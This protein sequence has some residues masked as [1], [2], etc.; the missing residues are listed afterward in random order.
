MGE[1]MRVPHPA[2]AS[3]RDGIFHCC[4]DHPHPSSHPTAEG[5]PLPC[6]FLPNSLPPSGVRR[7]CLIEAMKWRKM[8]FIT[9]RSVVKIQLDK[10]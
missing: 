9:P 7:Q 2:L 6:L 1:Q 3:D 10:T 4:W 5:Q 8:L